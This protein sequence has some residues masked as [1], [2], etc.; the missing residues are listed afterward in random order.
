ML[1]YSWISEEIL[2]KKKGAYFMETITDKITILDTSV[3]SEH[4]LKKVF[5]QTPEGDLKRRFLQSLIK[6]GVVVPSKECVVILG[7]VLEELDGSYTINGMLVDDIIAS[8]EFTEVITEKYEGEIDVLR[9][10]I[11]EKDDEIADLQADYCELSAT[12]A[13]ILSKPNGDE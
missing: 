11:E 3:F 6:S 2:Y 7:E 4:K 1:Q 5:V 13:E 10:T 12:L 9:A 8:E